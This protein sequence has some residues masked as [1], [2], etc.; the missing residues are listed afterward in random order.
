MGEAQATRQIT[1]GYRAAATGTHDEAADEA[2]LRALEQLGDRGSLS[3]VSFGVLS[4]RYN[5]AIANDGRI[6]ADEL[7]HGMELVHDIVL[8]NG[9]VAMER[10]PDG[11]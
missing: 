9:S 5:A 2:D 3:L 6:D 8:S 4:N 11:Q 1:A 10:Y 7:H